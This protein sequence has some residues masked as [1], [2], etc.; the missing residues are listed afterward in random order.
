MQINEIMLFIECCRL[1]Y[2]VFMIRKLQTASTA[3]NLQTP[4]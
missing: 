4:V 1:A 3:Y 2:A